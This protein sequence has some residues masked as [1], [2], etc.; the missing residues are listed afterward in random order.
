MQLKAFLLTITLCSVSLVFGQDPNFHL[1]L[2]FGQSNMEGAGTIEQQD[3]TIDDRFQVFQALECSNLGRSKA[4]WY[5]AVPPLCQ[6][7]SGLSPSDYFGRTMI[8]NLPDSIKVGVINVAVAG[9]DIRL[10]DKDIYQ[11]YDDTYTESWFIDKV[12]GYEGNPYSYLIDLAQQAQK[13]GI[14]KGILLHQGETNSG[15]N[16]WPSYVQKIYNDMLSD[17]SLDAESVPL[18]AGEMVSAAGNC[19]SGHNTIINTLPET[20]PTAHIISSDGCTAKDNAHF[21]SEGYRVFGRRYGEKM[22]SLLEKAPVGVGHVGEIR[23]GYDIHTIFPHPYNNPGSI[24]Y[25]SPGAEGVTLEIFDMNSRMMKVTSGKADGIGSHTIT[26]DGS[27]LDHGIYFYRL[28]SASGNAKSQK[29][30]LLE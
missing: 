12:N 4:E 17:L 10:F 6:C 22:L 27:G 13:D 29:M 3:K 25:F 30:L 23:E 21:D 5:T 2:C 16:K 14:I 11:D 26:F 19:C 24:T 28:K 20:I 18:L 1:Y 8:E 15:D 9:C 7:Y